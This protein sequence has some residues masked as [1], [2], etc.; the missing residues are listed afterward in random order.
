MTIVG[1]GTFVG[2]CRSCRKA[3]GPLEE[4]TVVR[5]GVAYRGFCGACAPT[6]QPQSAAFD[7]DDHEHEGLATMRDQLQHIDRMAEVALSGFGVMTPEGVYDALA[8][9][10]IAMRHALAVL[11]HYAIVGE[12]S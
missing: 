5:S 12:P 10:R 7:A 6:W 11:D 4:Y 3:L 2:R 1:G 9:T 8:D